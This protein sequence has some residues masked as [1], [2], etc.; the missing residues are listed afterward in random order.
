MISFAM[1]VLGGGKE[2]PDRLPCSYCGI[3][4]HDYEHCYQ[5]LGWPRSGCG[6]GRG[7][8]RGTGQQNNNST[9][10]GGCQQPQQQQQHGTQ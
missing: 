4:N 6:R 5:R 1:Q 3:N 10:G 2:R 7:R 8:G 9:C